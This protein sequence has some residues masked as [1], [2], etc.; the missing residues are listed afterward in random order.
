MDKMTQNKL[1]LDRSVVK[2]RFI[3]RKSKLVR[4]NTPNEQENPEQTREDS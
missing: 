4:K 2:T 1:K 3:L